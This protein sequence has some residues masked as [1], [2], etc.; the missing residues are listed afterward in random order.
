MRKFV[1]RRGSSVARRQR[2]LPRLLAGVNLRE[3]EAL[4]KG[5]QGAVADADVNVESVA[6]R[7][8]I[9]AEQLQE[10]LH[11]TIDLRLSEIR[12]ISIATGAIVEYR[13]TTNREITRSLALQFIADEVR[14]EVGTSGADFSTDEAMIAR[15]AAIAR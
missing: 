6:E 12:Q 10:S 14:D 7:I 5:L 4:L 15:I 11:G 9:T 1:Q 8:G 2:S 3:Q 13:V